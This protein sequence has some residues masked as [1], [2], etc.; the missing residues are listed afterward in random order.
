MAIGSSNFDHR[1]AMFNNEIDA[2]VL[3]SRVADGEALFNQ[4]VAMSNEID[5]RTWRSR[6]L[7]ERFRE[8]RARLLEFLL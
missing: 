5:L 7:D 8:W 2:I 4:D 6:P 3:G 1:S